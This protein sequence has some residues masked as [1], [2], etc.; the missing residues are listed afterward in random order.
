MASMLKVLAA[1]FVA[2][3]G[4]V[5]RGA[6]QDESVGEVQQG[7]NATA[8]AFK[9]S[10][11]LPV[12]QF[13]LDKRNRDCPFFEDSIE[14]VQKQAAARGAT[15]TTQRI[16]DCF[17]KCGYPSGVMHMFGERMI[18]YPF[19]CCPDECYRD[20]QLDFYKCAKKC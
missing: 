13:M 4:A 11:F 2:S 10:D 12:Y 19:Q 3:Q 8:A 7:G 14:M 6:P 15:L 1:M 20:D 16:D 17:V 5:L 18:K 9:D